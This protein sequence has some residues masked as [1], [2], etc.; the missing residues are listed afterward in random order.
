MSLLLLLLPNAC[1]LQVLQQITPRGAAS[2][3]LLIIDRV[4]TTGA[5]KTPAM[6]SAYIVEQSGV[7]RMT[8]K[9]SLAHADGAVG[10]SKGEVAGITQRQP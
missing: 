9:A 8:R 7:T 5:P 4:L 2:P 1:W 10:V 3:T 6:N